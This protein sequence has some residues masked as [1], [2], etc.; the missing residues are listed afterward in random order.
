[1]SQVK[2]PLAP[3]AGES[4]MGLVA[5]VTAENGYPRTGTL[6]AEAGWVYDNKPTAAT[7]NAE[8]L[9]ALADILVVP[10]P[11]LLHHAHGPEDG[12]AIIHWFGGRAWQSELRTTIRRYAPASLAL[13]AHHRAIWQLAS[14]PFCPETFQILRSECH[15]CGVT[16]RWRYANGIATCDQD[17][18]SADLREGPAEFIPLEM[19]DNLGI[20]AGLFS[21]D[22]DVR[23]ASR[24]QFPDPIASLE[25]H[26]IA[27]LALKL[28]PWLNDQLRGKWLTNPDLTM[29]V[30][31]ALHDAVTLL[32]QWPIVPAQLLPTPGE[33]D[34]WS[35]KLGHAVKQAR[36][37]RSSPR[38]KALFAMFLH[39]LQQEQPDLSQ[40][41]DLT[42]LPSADEGNDIIGLISAKSAVRV[43]R[44]T[45]TI[46]AKLRAA[47]V[48]K[49]TDV[50]VHGVVRPFHDPEEIE[51]LARTKPDRLPLTAVSQSTQLPRYAIAQL[52]QSGLLA[53]LTHPYWEARYG[54]RNTTTKAWAAFEAKIQAKADPAIVDGIPLQIA[55]RAIG[56]RA[57]PW[58]GI[59]AWLLGPDGRFGLAPE[60]TDLSH[61]ILI[62]ADLIDTLRMLENPLS[63]AHVEDELSGTDASE[64]LNLATNQFLRFVATGRI[65]RQGKAYLA[66]DVLQ[67]AAEIIGSVEI[68]YRMGLP[69]QSAQK[70]ARKV[71]L[72]TIHDAGYCRMRFANIMKQ[73]AWS[74]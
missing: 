71:G 36:I 64:I 29:A 41:P 46:I 31:S 27:D 11:Q 30:V 20:Y 8:H 56:G 54:V 26:D 19:R 63:G 6:L 23:A 39:G 68:G 38:V 69:P 5:R 2:Y 50:R 9:P 1:M 33:G 74:A 17:V 34:N 37:G 72:P 18:C 10:Y 4:L 48:F 60:A 43:L 73:G 3:I 35:N 12:S 70:W 45:D 16:Q 52:M 22:P 32:R 7:T 65:R 28:S 49:L 21:H 42:D 15:E 58:A 57:K 53:P 62:P 47:G 24:S 59:F 55:A 66:A 44:E 13:S 14:V 61:Q 51:E 40:S 25:P 67:A